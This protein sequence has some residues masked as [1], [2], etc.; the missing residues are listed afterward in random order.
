MM[1][2][3]GGTM[4]FISR[5]LRFVLFYLLAG[6]AWSTTAH[7]VT[8]VD[9]GPYDTGAFSI[10]PSDGYSDAF[11][12]QFTTSQPWIVTSVGGWLGSVELVTG[13][14]TA[15]IYS[16][17]SD[18]LPLDDLFSA[19]IEV[20]PDSNSP[21]EFRSVDTDWFLPAGTYWLAFF[22]AEGC[23]TD[24]EPGAGAGG[25]YAGMK[26]TGLA[27]SYTADGGAHWVPYDYG[28][29]AVIQ[30]SPVP[31]PAALWLFGSAIAGGLTL[32]RRRRG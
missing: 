1:V 22:A 5:G 30:G 17:G 8:I 7:A 11:A 20:P 14:V 2:M 23:E 32:A 24:T 25:C 13:W 6:A 19:Q 27:S 29:A 31:V 9:T 28:L 12:G 15:V 3:R 16:N 18:N 10:S 26:G 21:L 4:T